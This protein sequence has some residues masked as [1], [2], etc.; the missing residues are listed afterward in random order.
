MFWMAAELEAYDIH[1]MMLMEF[2]S[3]YS[4]KRS[5]EGM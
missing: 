5:S 3:Y 4:K 2:N 1:R